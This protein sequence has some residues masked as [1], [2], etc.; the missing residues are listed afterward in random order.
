M[1]TI[2]DTAREKILALGKAEQRDDLALRFGIDGR[3]PQGFV[4]RLRFVESNDRKPTD[5]VVKAG[6]MDV[7]IDQESAPNLKGAS[8]DYVEG[9][10]GGGFKIENPNPLWSDTKAQM[11][12]QVIDAQINPAVASHGGTV[13][14]LDV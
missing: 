13:T 11:V 6:E 5:K 3:G 2:T 8:L 14:L 4:Y 1:V 12:Q 10:E 9:P 7:L